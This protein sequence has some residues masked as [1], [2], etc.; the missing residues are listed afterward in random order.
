MRAFEEMGHKVD[1]IGHVFD[2]LGVLWGR[3]SSTSTYATIYPKLAEDRERFGHAFLTGA[4]TA[5]KITWEQ[6]RRG[7]AGA[8]AAREPARGVLREVRPAADA[9]AAVRRDRRARQLAEGDRRQAAEEPAA[10]RAVHAAV[11]PL[12]PP[13]DQRAQRLQRPRPA[14]RPPDRRRRATAT[15]SSCRP[16]TPSSR[17]GRGTTAGR[18]KWPRWRCDGRTTN[19]F[20]L[21]T[22]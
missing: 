4:L 21:H 15:T 19:A 7:A 22:M 12:R 2:D 18:W 6:V 10:R 13:G 16:R 5:K 17:R 3:L 20:R 9:D 14:G 11:Q 8:G 1:E